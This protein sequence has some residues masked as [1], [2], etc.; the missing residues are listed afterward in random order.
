[1][2]LLLVEDEPEVGAMLTEALGHR[3][4][5]VDWVRTGTDGVFAAG[6]QSYDVLLLDVGLPDISGLDA[7]RQIRARDADVGVIML[8]GRGGVSHR[9][10]GLDAGADDY[11]PKPVSLAELEARMRAVSRRGVRP[12]VQ[13]LTV[14]DLEVVPAS[15]TVSRAGRAVAVA[16]REYALVE[17]LARRAGHVV[18]RDEIVSQLWDRAAEV[19]D[20]AVDVLV[21]GVR[22]KVDAPFVGPPLVETVRGV[23]YRL[24]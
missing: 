6:E 14:R 4:H 24:R 7:C 21:A 19:S 22:R 9:V 8:T 23:G 10:E 5:V 17:M 15:R 13:T 20:N 3:G 12:V 16:G 11:V 18:R 1:M 2:R